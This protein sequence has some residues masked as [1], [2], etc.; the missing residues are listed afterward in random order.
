[1]E[2]AEPYTLCKAIW[3]L[4]GCRATEDSF[5]AVG[6][7]ITVS[8]WTLCDIFTLIQQTA[9]SIET[10]VCRELIQKEYD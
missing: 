4:A 8:L 9:T 10:Q 6:W 5:F 7:I 2:N 3:A 1:M